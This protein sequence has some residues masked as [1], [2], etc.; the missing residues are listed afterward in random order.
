MLSL[1]IHNLGDVTI[2]R[3]A[4]RIM[5]PCA[6]TLR[7]AV[8]RQPR[9]RVVVLDLA[10]ISAVD[11]AGLGILVSLRTWARTTGTALKLMNLTPRVEFLLEVTNLRS[12]F[13]ICSVQDMLELLCRA[14]QQSLLVGA[15][16]LVESFGR[17]PLNTEPASMQDQG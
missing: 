4:G 12:V 3:C 11:A 17:T 6:D 1:T 9:F 7:T 8:L 16:L 15:E 2:F 13:E 5:F 10:E 14:V